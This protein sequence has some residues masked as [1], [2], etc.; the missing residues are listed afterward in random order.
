MYLAERIIVSCFKMM[1][2]PGAG[3]HLARREQRRLTRQRGRCLPSPVHHVAR[4]P[5]TL[6]DSRKDDALV[7]DIVQRRK[8][9]LIESNAKCVIIFMPRWY[10]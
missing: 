6:P 8:I 1:E 5:V 3:F 4:A 2:E 10:T 7:L 9:R